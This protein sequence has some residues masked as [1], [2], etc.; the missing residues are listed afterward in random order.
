MGLQE[1]Q[2]DQVLQELKVQLDHREIR[3]LVGRLDH[4]DQSD[5]VAQRDLLE[6]LEHKDFL[7]HQGQHRPEDQL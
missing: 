2:E 1:V 4:L 7:D 3:D 6:T 5:Q